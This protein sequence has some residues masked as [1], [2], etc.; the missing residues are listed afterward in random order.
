MDINAWSAGQGC[1]PVEEEC[2][3]VASVKEEHDDWD[4]FQQE[5]NPVSNTGEWDPVKVEPTSQSVTERWDFLKQA[6][7]SVSEHAE[8]DEFDPVKQESKFLSVTEDFDSV[9][10]GS[11]SPAV[12]HGE[13][14]RTSQTRKNVSSACWR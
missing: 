2:S 8:G 1:H 14:W 6:S 4:P 11:S 9:N 12:F 13:E 7:T 5:S 10:Q 3:T